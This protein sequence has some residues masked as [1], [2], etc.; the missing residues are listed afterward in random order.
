M[1]TP[2]SRP[3]KRTEKV[4]RLPTDRL[5]DQPT[6]YHATLELYTRI[7]AVLLIS[8]MQVESPQLLQQILKTKAI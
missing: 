5:C 3:S 1:L 8:V 6:N 7:W 4:T 2:S